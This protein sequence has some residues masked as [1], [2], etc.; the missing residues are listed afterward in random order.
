MMKKFVLIPD[1]FKGT[2]SSK[3]ICEIM[4]VKIKEQFPNAKTVSIPVADG[5]E[6]SVDCFLTAL[7][8][9][10]IFVKCKGPYFEDIQGFYGLIGDGKTAVIEM[11]ATA[12][13]P[14]V[15]NNKNPLKTTT[16]GVV[17]AG[18]ALTTLVVALRRRAE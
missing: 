13:L 10:K 5:G 3:Q 15:E 7:G 1:S 4:S 16:Y 18:L 14:L 17:L 12:G 6:G 8:G 2:L 9:Q 11:A